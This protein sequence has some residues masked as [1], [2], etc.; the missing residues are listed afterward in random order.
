M[1][2]LQHSGENTSK[3]SRLGVVIA[4]LPSLL[5][6]ALF[7]SL[8]FHMHR[9]LGGWPNYIG[10]QGFSPWLVAHA[11]VTSDYFIASLFCAFILVP[12][13]IVACLRSPEHRK[14]VTY[15]AVCGFLFFVSWF[16]MGLAPKPFLNWWN[17]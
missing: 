5:L 2:R 15:I 17:D 1:K 13:G 12:L 4:L 8:A 9:A 3:V 6:L 14:Y 7:Y 16:V 10:E 11:A